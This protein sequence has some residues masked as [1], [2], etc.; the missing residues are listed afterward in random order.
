MLKSDD[1]VKEQFRK[2]DEYVDDILSGKII[3]NT[4][5]KQ[6]V[7]N[8]KENLNRK[9]LEYKKDKVEKVFKFFSLLRANINNEIKQYE[10][11]PYQTFIIVNLFGFYRKG[12][13][14]RKY[15]YF[16]LF[17]ARKNAKTYFATALNLYFLVA[18]GELNPQSILLASTTKQSGVALNYAKDMVNY[19]PALKKRI[20][21]L[22]YHLRFIN[23]G[24]TGTMQTLAS[25][26]A[27][28]LDGFNP[29]SVILDE[30][31]TYSDYSIYN[32]VKSGIGARKNPMIMMITT[33]GF[34]IDGFCY[35]IFETSKK[36]LSKEI[37]DDSFLPM[38]YTLD[39]DDD[40]NNTDN[41]IKSNP[42]LNYTIPID[43]LIREF[44]Q[45]KNLPSL[46]NSFLTKNLNIF[47]SE[48]T[49]WINEEKLRKC[50]KPIPDDEY[51]SSLPCYI[52]IDLSS[53][54]DLTS[55]VCLFYDEIEDK[56]YT[57]PFF[58]RANNEEKRIR[59][60]GLDLSQWINNK[61]I[62]QFD[63]EIID[64][65]YLYDFIVELSEKYNINYI[66]YDKWNSTYLIGKI[67]YEL[68][69][70]CIDVSQT[71][72][73]FNRPLKFIEEMIYDE[74]LIL[75]NNPVL[76][77]NFHNVVIP[78]PDSYGNIKL[79]KNKKKDSIDGVV[80]LGMAIKLFID[81]NTNY[82]TD[83]IDAY[84][85]MNK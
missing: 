75:N 52:G 71:A 48:S 81:N 45:T 82:T 79:D 40:I 67:K 44:Q 37:E 41:W 29:S 49:Q 83:F 84:S 62:H 25:V 14:K 7:N 42:S 4:Y 3:S 13:D 76:F 15:N 20:D 2:C 18:D 5:I 31:H 59:K 19:S 69:I 57:K 21:T 72:G 27:D 16:F 80:A 8:Y 55:I 10:L 12:T 74:K 39:D 1:Y 78:A 56:L 46:L 24:S 50:K 65:E 28:S 61:Y 35:D 17:I 6:V 58:F 64:Y 11:L 23:K 26:N 38:L 47:T 36:I 60:G 85:Q 22:Q 43:Y 30:V 34:N 68:S 32:V 63:K 70:E 77:W 73:Q 33:A 53:T 66:G 54:R 51:L 9:D